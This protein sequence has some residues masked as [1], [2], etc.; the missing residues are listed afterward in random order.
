MADTGNGVFPVFYAPSTNPLNP[1]RT[2]LADSQDNTAWAVF[3]D[4]TMDL[5]DAWELSLAT[6]FDEDQREQTTLTPPAF[7]VALPQATFG[8]VRTE[9]FSQFQPKITLRYSV[10]D[11]LSVYGGY[12]RGFRSGGFNQSG[13]ADAAAAA[14]I[15]GVG[16][17]FRAEVAD[18]FEAGFKAQ[19][20][21]GRLSVNGAAYHT[22]S[23]NPYFFVFLASNSTQNLGNIDE[24]EYV[25]FELDGTAR[26]TDELSLNLGVGMTDSEITDF[27]D[28]SA[29]GNEAPLV[30]KYT[31]NLGAEYL[32]TIARD[33]DLR[34]RVDWQ[35]IG[36]T[37]WEPF[38]ITKRDPVDLVDVRFG[39]ESGNW[40]F[41]AWS[42]NAFDEEYN[43]EFSPGGFLWKGMPRRYGLDLTRRF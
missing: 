17:I 38:N 27:T 35:R 23:E 28:P 32:V 40:S 31:L 14:G 30:S 9:T 19:L 20:A 42:K 1:Q 41:V 29:I 5:G 26:L 11:D 2:F 12:S 13:V 34:A 22:T 6:R 36:D 33:L 25:G 15:V 39:I 43:A 16:D 24:V 3:G 4:L 7:L 10:S 21:D 8:E 37:Y 18:T